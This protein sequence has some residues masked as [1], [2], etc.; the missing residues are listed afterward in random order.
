[1][2]LQDYSELLNTINRITELKDL[3]SL[4]AFSLRKTELIAGVKSSLL[5]IFKSGTLMPETTF[6]DVNGKVFISSDILPLLNINNDNLKEDK[7][8]WLYENDPV[9]QALGLNVQSALY[10]HF[11]THGGLQCGIFLIDPT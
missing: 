2:L 3:E 11:Y 4:T 9:L 6:Y 5:S 8:T 1:M 7:G 10:F